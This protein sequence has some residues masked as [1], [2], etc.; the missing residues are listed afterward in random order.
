MSRRRS[1]EKRELP[2]DPRYHDLI[3][4]KF[5]NYCMKSGKRSVAER[6]VYR[7]FDIINEKTG[8]IVVGQHH[9]DCFLPLYGV[10]ANLP[11]P[12][13]PPSSVWNSGQQISPPI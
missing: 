10:S 2:P 13:T 3:V 11:Q 12:M 8:T 5:V 4:T 6:M 9:L 7:A 1:P